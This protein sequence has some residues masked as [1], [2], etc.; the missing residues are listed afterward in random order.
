MNWEFQN[1][2]SDD[3][4]RIVFIHSLRYI[5]KILVDILKRVFIFIST[6]IIFFCQKTNIWSKIYIDND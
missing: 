5:I 2:D 1:D 6:L 4:L 3:Y